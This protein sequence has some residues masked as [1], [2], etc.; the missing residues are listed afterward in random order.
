MNEKQLKEWLKANLKIT[1][2]TEYDSN[3]VTVGLYFEGDPID[4][5]KEQVCFS[6]VRIYIE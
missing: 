3:S 4:R 2:I 1:T 6:Q 5:W